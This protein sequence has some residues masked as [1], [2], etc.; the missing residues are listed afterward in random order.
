[1]EGIIYK[2]TSKTSGKCYIGET[3]ASLPERINKHFN[4][5]KFCKNTPDKLFKFQKAILKYGEQDFVWEILEKISADDLTVLKKNLL[6]KE[7]FYIQKYDSY[8]QGYNSKISIFS[9]DFYIKNELIINLK[10]YL[11]ILAQGLNRNQQAIYFNCKPSS[12][13]NYRKKLREN[14]PEL[15][16]ILKQ[17]DELATK[18]GML[19]RNT[20]KAFG[21]LN[22]SYIKIDINLEKY[23][24]EANKGLNRKQL[25]QI[26]NITEQHLKIWKR[27][28]VE[29]NKEYYLKLFKDL[30]GIRRKNCSSKRKTIN[31]LSEDIINKV[32]A[33]RK[34]LSMR[35]IADRLRLPFKTIRHLCEQLEKENIIC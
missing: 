26:F 21:E 1:M 28:K 5:T 16:P 19:A 11:E 14:N 10:E 8:H 13:K 20:Y 23:I 35:A 12:I 2:A 4:Y 33:M 6:E 15:I 25:A 9:E 34:N 29:E 30:E 32:Q 27:R 18:K 7:A 17:Y 24:L 31:A 22:S 3:C